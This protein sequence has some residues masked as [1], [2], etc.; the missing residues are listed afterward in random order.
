M[1]SPDARK[2]PDV[3]DGLAQASQGLRVRVTAYAR[4][5]LGFLNLCGGLGW[6]YGS[7][8]VGLN[9]PRTRVWAETARGF[10]A[11]GPHADK[12]VRLA[13]RLARAF[14]TRWNAKLTVAQAIPGHFGLGSGTQWALAVG[15]ALLRLHGIAASARELAAALGRGER[16]GI[17]IATFEKGGFIL[18]AGHRPCPPATPDK[19][20][21]VVLRRNFPGHWRFVLALPKAPEGLCGQEEQE[22]FARLGDTRAITGGICQ[23]V[24]LRLL[25]AL[26]EVDIAAFG[27]AMTD[28]DRQTGLLF[29]APQG[30]VYAGEA[31]EIIGGLLE[32]G[33]YGAGQSS[34]GP[35]LYALVDDANQDRVLACAMGL[36]KASGGR[37]LLARARNRGADVSVRS[38]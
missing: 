24:Q 16:S 18:D 21:E 17:G 7:L 34:W 3:P 19:P 28:L 29:S 20:S 2:G 31:L 14:R 15:T 36:V 25:P 12:A 13:G 10:S 30:G 27:Q 38:V 37:A 22:A 32:A 33:A 4:L 8:G 1:S 5:H 23:T 11:H 9:A 6:K 26:A 35:C